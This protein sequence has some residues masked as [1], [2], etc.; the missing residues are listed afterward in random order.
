MTRLRGAVSLMLVLGTTL[1]CAQTRRT[2]VVEHPENVAIATAE[3]AGWGWMPWAWDDNNLGNCMANDYWF[4]MT[5]QCGRYKT[6]DDLTAFGKA[7]VPMI[8]SMS[9]KASIFN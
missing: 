1:L 4:S 8:Q 5:L 2:H 6:V 3:A 9:V 7:I